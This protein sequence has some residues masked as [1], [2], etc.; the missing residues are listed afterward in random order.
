[1]RAKNSGESVLSDPSFAAATSLSSFYG[2]G[3]GK[4]RKTQKEGECLCPARGW[5]HSN[6]LRRCHLAFLRIIR[7]SE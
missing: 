4:N 1:M 7:V 5:A 6:G 2:A 3:G